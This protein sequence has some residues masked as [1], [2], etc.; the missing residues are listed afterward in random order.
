MKRERVLL[1]EF[2]KGNQKVTKGCRGKGNV[3]FWKFGAQGSSRKA[4]GGERGATP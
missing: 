2:L 4:L 3:F 1:L